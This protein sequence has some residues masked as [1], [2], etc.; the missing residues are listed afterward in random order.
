[1]IVLT[2][3]EALDLRVTINDLV[4][5]TSI[6][7]LSHSWRCPTSR[8]LAQSRAKRTAVDE[9]VHPRVHA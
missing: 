6:I 4:V 3:V 9:S 8:R 7:H 2:V 5:S 1:M